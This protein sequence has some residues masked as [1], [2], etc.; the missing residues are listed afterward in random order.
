MRAPSHERRS[1]TVVRERATVSMDELTS[2]DALEALAPEWRALWARSPSATPFQS[3][4]WLLPWWRHFGR[5][6][7][8][9]L[10]LRDAGALVGVAPF[11]TFHDGA[12]RPGRLVLLGTGNSDRLDALFDAGFEERGAG[13]VLARVTA[14]GRDWDVCDLQRLAPSSPLLA[15]ASPDG[16]TSDVV[17]E[18]PCPV[19]SLPAS[20]EGIEAVVSRGFARRLDYYA[21]RAARAGVVRVEAADERTLGEQ[22]DALFA[23]HEARWRRRHEP[24]TLGDPVVRSFHREAAAALL[25]GG[26]LRCYALRLGGRIIAVYHGFADRRRSYYYLGGFDPELETLSPGSLLVA[27]AVREAMREGAREVDFLRGR[28]PYK[29]RW[30]ATDRPTYRRLLRRRL[31]AGP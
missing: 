31:A 23:L 27:H 26:A 25:R 6:E 17:E 22:L 8:L 18:E 13:A 19:L 16:V 20:A 24:G 3:P 29:Y 15:A 21:R 12:G 1:A 11:Y 4:D 30:G 9:V 10:A 2:A 14:G 7:P 5:G 28:E